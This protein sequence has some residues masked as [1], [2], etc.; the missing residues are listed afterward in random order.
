M[1][2]TNTLVLRRPD[3]AVDNE[4]GSG[5]LTASCGNCGEGYFEMT[6][7]LQWEI[8]RLGLESRRQ[9]SNLLPPRKSRLEKRKSAKSENRLLYGQ[10]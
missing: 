6:P 1:K 5:T 7:T 8:A 9:I 3:R 2:I 4:R 10:A